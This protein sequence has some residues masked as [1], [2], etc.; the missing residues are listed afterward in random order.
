[1]TKKNILSIWQV[2]FTYI[3]ALV[4]AGFASGQELLKFFTVF[5]KKGVMGA[6]ISGFLFGIFGFL[7]FRVV[8][9]EKIENYGQLL[10]FLFG[11]RIA[12]FVEG[13]LSLFLLLC[14]AVMFVAGGSLF[15]QLWSFPFGWGFFLTALVVGSVLLWG[16][17]GVLWLNTVLIPGLILLSLVIAV[18]SL[19]PRG[20]TVATIA[21]LNLVGENWLLATC[22]YVSYNFILGSVIL[23]SLGDL[24][25]KGGEKGV[26][27]GGLILGLMAGL[28]SFALLKQFSYV[29]K[30][31]IPLLVLAYGI[32]PSLGWAYSFMLWVAIFTTALSIGFGLLKRGEQLLPL[33]K[34]FIIALLFAS[35]LPF[36]YWSF[37]QMITTIYPFIGYGGFVFLAVLLFKTL[38]AEI[39]FRWRK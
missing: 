14:L 31:T 2:A 32:H 3:G 33:P 29:K 38:P 11:K 19:C 28:I 20:L 37:P 5:G 16:Q 17:E 6:V 13:L 1:M 12:L 26:L 9:R 4:G 8:T 36:L 34:V 39:I 23:A 27:L 21:Q 30:Q 25:K 18:L 22:L 24:D 7:V 15:H 10:G 35:T